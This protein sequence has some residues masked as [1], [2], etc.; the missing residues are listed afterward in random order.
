MRG[1]AAA[2]FR[3]PA[4]A[5]AGADMAASDCLLRGEEEVAG[6]VGRGGWDLG[7][8][9]GEVGGASLLLQSLIPSL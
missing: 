2:F 8:W 3:L 4:E 6:S 1:A 7:A 5:G 9:A